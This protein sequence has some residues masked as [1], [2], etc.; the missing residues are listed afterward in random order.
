MFF[1]GL[2]AM[3]YHNPKDFDFVKDF[4]NKTEAI[5][6]EYL[7]LKKAYGDKD[8]YEKHD[9]EHTLNNG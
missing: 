3:P 6:K 4:E 9:G 2:K 5:K 8:D 1:P 7:S